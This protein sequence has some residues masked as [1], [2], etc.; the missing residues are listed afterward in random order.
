[1]CRWQDEHGKH[2]E[3][4]EVEFHGDGSVVQW[5]TERAVIGGDTWQEAAEDLAQMASTLGQRVLD[6]TQDPPRM[7]PWKEAA[8]ED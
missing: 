7:I 6:L 2:F 8:G 5:S 4:R 3:V 1:M